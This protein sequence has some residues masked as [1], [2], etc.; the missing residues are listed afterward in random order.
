MHV[1]RRTFLEAG[2]A[3][4][5]G[6]AATASFTRAARAQTKSVTATFSILGIAVTSTAQLEGEV[7]DGAAFETSIEP[8]G[9]NTALA[10][11]RL[12][13]G[14]KLAVSRLS[15]TAPIPLT[16]VQ[17]IWYTQQLDGL[18]QHAYIGLPWSVDIPAAGHDG[19]LIAGAQ[20]RYGRNRGLMAL[21]NQSGDGALNFGN[22]YAGKSL[23]L[24]I[25]R[26][27][28]ERPFHVDGI[29]ETLYLSTEDI[30][31]NEA[32]GRFVEWYDRA[33][34]LSYD[35]P[36]ACFEPVWNTWYPSLGKVDDAF[37][38][39]NARTCARLGFRTLIIDA[40]W[41]RAEGDWEPKKE[42]FP[43]FRATIDRL[44]SLGLRAIIWYRPFGFDPN[45][46][47][48]GGLAA[49]N[50]VVK[51]AATNNLCPRCREVRERAGRIAGELME[52]YGLDGL[53][54]DFLDASP[55]SAPLVNCEAAHTHDFDF[56]SDSVRDAM[57]LM[58]ESVRRVKPDAIIEFRLNYANVANRIYGNCYRGQDTPSD[59]DLGRRHLALIRSWCRGVAPHSD[60][61]YWALS[62][63]DENVARYLATSMLYAVPT[64]SVNFPDLPPNHTALVRAWLAFYHEHKARLI[65]GRFD[66]LSDDPHCSVARVSS[67]GRTYLP[68]FLRTW[69]ASLPVIPEHAGTII[70]FNGASKPHILTRLEGAEGAYRLSAT[71][72]FHRP[73]GKPASVRSGRGA[74]ELDV[75]VDVGGLAVLKREGSA[76]K[77]RGI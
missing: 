21:K 29:D 42:A 44:H 25:N 15:V 63:T 40:G 16:D 19:S 1:T 12:L 70:L 54:I 46:A 65:T 76:R 48:A 74:L 9:R 41:F 59:P 49:F 14:R 27:A 26:F 22:G 56:V 28:V 68:C 43:D 53:K 3:A 24:T 62:E 7:P 58:A 38:N 17:R 64:L 11:I 75:P 57:R 61:N 52:R 39:A 13:P 4:G 8:L 35:T 47:T 45:A 77:G 33:H 31:W 37:I 23:N 6:I 32:V 20:S 10:R 30:P 69:P 50:T 67:G 2:L 60:P 71:D 66:P 73:A 51:G 55:A 34:G 36:A 5:A 72:M 18:G